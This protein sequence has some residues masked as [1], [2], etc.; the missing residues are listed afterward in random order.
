MK[1]LVYM[2]CTS[3]TLACALRLSGSQLV[4]RMIGIKDHACTECIT[5]SNMGWYVDAASAHR[6][7]D[8]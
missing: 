6:K 7:T 8:H 2:G 3:G 4:V 1:M 5:H